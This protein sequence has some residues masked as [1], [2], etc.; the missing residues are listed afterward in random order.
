[1]RG[2][3][4][5]GDLKASDTIVAIVEY[6]DCGFHASCASSRKM[7]KFGGV[8][9]SMDEEEPGDFVGLAA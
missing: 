8:E 9:R 6:F 7:S 1:M 3:M 4:V 2:G 5:F